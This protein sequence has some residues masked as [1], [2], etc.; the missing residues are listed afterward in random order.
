MARTIYDKPT[1]ALLKDM[2]TAWDLKPGQVFT[3]S[4]AIE[5]FATNYPKLKPGSIRAH[6]VQASTNDRGRL[7]HPA[8]NETDD[9]LFKVG[10][11]QFRR[12]EPDKEGLNKSTDH[13]PES[14]IDAKE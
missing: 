7:H 8:T 6:L 9:I 1:R 5:W 4:R 12:Y 11:G 14:L 13:A 10:P 3:S 2:L